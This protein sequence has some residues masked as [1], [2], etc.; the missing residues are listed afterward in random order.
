M[1]KD[2]VIL[3]NESRSLLRVGSEDIE[4]SDYNVK[5]SANGDTEL[6]VT[7]KGKVAIFELTANLEE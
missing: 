6:S 4:I 3:R 2:V 7:I 1:K 5:S